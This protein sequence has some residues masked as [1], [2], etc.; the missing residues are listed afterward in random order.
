VKFDG[1]DYPNSGR[2]ATPGSTSSIRRVNDH[3][4]KMTCKVDG[5]VLYTQQIELSTDLKTLTVTRLIVGISEP[6]IRVFE[7]Q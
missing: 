3:A 7:R 5:K 1:N 2:N 6:N 4:L